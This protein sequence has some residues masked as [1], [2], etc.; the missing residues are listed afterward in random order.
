MRL[1]LWL[2]RMSYLRVL[3]PVAAVARLRGWDVVAF[4]PKGGPKSDAAGQ[5]AAVS[6]QIG[7]AAVV[8]EGATEA[9]AAIRSW[10][11]KAILSASV[12]VEDWV[13]VVMGETRD[14]CLW[15]AVGYL[16]EEIVWTLMEGPRVLR[17]W[18]FVTTGS[19]QGRDQ[20]AAHY[21]L[22]C[23]GDD[24]KR[25]LVVTGYPPL[26]TFHSLTREACRAKFGIKP[27]E[28]VILFI[29]AARPWGLSWW[30]RAAFDGPLAWAAPALGVPS[31]RRVVAAVIR[32]AHRHSARIIMKTRAKNQDPAW[33][34]T[35]FSQVVGDESW[36]PH[37]TLEL[38][39]A[40]DL[41]IGIASATAVEAAAAGVPSLHIFT[42]PDVA[43]VPAYVP[44]RKEF[45]HES[46]LWHP[47]L[48]ADRDP[49]LL[50]DWAEGA[51][52]QSSNPRPAERV[53]RPMC[54]TVDGLA[55]DRVMDAVEAR[56]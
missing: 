41:Y 8:V 38:L 5:R 34:D 46:L 49:R 29:P 16:Q 30:R 48:Q 6:R 53:I 15:G 40:A 27:D 35:A 44:F 36:Y 52:W 42:W 2:P 4:C 47:R 50:E 24:I 7:G 19:E 37:T 26:D 31:Y 14:T 43:N 20:L 22:M 12:K 51:E 25:K 21:P 55:S 9:T 54:G 10:R 32:Y 11:P 23:V 33:L 1:G 17:I 39:K 18:D 45:F 56:V 3:G 28:R 13:H